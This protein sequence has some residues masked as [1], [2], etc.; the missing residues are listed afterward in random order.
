MS[1][2]AARG[3]ALH[4]LEEWDAALQQLTR[5]DEGAEGM[6]VAPGYLCEQRLHR[7]VALSV[8]N[9]LVLLMLLLNHT[10]GG[11]VPGELKR[12]P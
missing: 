9:V 5:P 12:K 3:H 4:L 7:A 11:S 1:M 2:L 6:K 8:L 10:H